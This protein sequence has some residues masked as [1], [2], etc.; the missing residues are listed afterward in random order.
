MGMFLY[1]LHRGFQAFAA[2]LRWS[3]PV[4]PWL[5]IM[6]LGA[7]LYH[8]TPVVGPRAVSA[9]LKRDLVSMTESRD[10]YQQKEAE[11]ALSL[12]LCRDMRRV[13]QGRATRAIDE[14][15]EQCRAD[16]AAARRSAVIIEKLIGE[17]EDE[18][19]ADDGDRRLIDPDGLREALKPGSRPAGG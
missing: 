17:P 5:A 3:A 10:H 13:D 15:S 11:A 4:W 18:D 14:Q 16:I 9:G 8:W 12:K 2:F 1:G 19:P 7:I 6:A